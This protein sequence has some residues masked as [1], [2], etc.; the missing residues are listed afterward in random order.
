MTRTLLALAAILASLAPL[1]IAE[2]PTVC[3]F[4]QKQRHTLD[5]DAVNLAKSLSSQKGG[6]AFDF[7]PIGGFAGKDIEAEAQHRNCAWNLTLQRQEPP[8]D[9]PNYAGTLGGGRSSSMSGGITNSTIAGNPAFQQAQQDGGMLVYDLR[10][11]DSR[12]VVAHGE[13]TDLSS[14]DPLAASI[15]KKLSKAK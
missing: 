12:K 1:A 10:K 6:P 14:Y 7:V 4:Q 15:E 13:T 9:T 11:A 8:P 3:I 5:V 2:N